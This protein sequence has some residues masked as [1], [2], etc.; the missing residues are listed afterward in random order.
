MTA[1][2]KE[3]VKEPV[4]VREGLPDFDAPTERNGHVGSGNGRAF[5][6]DTETYNP[7][8]DPAELFAEGERR[9]R[10]TNGHA[11]LQLGGPAGRLAPWLVVLI[12]AA[13]GLAVA[14]AEMFGGG[15]ALGRAN[16]APTVFAVFGLML[17][18]S[19]YFISTRRRDLDS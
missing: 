3:P 15:S 10:Q 8:R 4:V 16:A 6:D 11:S 7:G 19:L 2:V 13:L 18:M 14:F 12:L 17:V 5:I 1:P 9:E